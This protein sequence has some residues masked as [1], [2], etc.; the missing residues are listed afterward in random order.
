[1]KSTIKLIA[2]LFI[3]SHVL[4]AD[5]SVVYQSASSTLIN[6]PA[7]RRLEIRMI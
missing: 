2:L 4:A 3:S 7:A 6:R 5:L 1:M